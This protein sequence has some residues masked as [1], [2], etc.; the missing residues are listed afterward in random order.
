M[1]DELMRRYA[2]GLALIMILS[3]ALM[4]QMSSKGPESVL[5]QDTAPTSPVNGQSWLRGTDL[6]RFFYSD[7][8]GKWLGESRMWGYGKSSAD[9][10][11]FLNY[12]TS[13]A[14]DTTT[15]AE[16]GAVAYGVVR[17]MNAVGRS[18]VA[19]ASTTYVFAAQDTIL[20]LVWDQTAGAIME[21]NPTADSSNSWIAPSNRVVIP[22]GGVVSMAY[23]D[24]AGP[25]PDRPSASEV[26]LWVREEVT[27]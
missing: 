2:A 21:W 23:V 20:K 4:G 10:T 24:S 8:L 14:S 22:D 18:S 3:V 6:Q 25:G 12:H 5:V 27:P 9:Y 13:G 17:I 7:S 15:A 26:A 1:G 16:V 11:G 19:A